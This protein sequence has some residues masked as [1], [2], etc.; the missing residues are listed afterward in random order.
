MKKVYA[1]II[2][3]FS[4][5]VFSNAQN[6]WRNAVDA[7]EIRY[8]SQQPVILYTLTID[9]DDLTRFIVDMDIR[10]APDTLRVAM[11]THPEY[12]DKYYRYVEGMNAVT[13]SGPA[14]IIREDSMLW[15]IE[16]R[17]KRVQLHY[18]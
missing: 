3:F 17:S 12:D 6:P 14:R 15:R 16:T 5:A 7:F 11:F 13:P 9:A 1:L 18:A 10:N 4:T 8:S 2:I